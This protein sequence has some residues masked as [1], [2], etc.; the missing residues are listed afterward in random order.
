M[1]DDTFYLNP[2]D[3]VVQLPALS[4]TRQDAGEGHRLLRL[5]RAF[6]SADGLV[7]RLPDI[8]WGKWPNAIIEMNDHKGTLT[9]VWRDAEAQAL[10]GWALES[11]WNSLAEYNLIDAFEREDWWPAATIT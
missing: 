2:R 1:K 5:A 11:A 10:F 4:A 3:E 8:M 9:V 7:Y 6:G